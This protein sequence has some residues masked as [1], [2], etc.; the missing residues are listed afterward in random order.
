MCLGM[1]SHLKRSIPDLRPHKSS[2][3][4][5]IGKF[6]VPKQEFLNNFYGTIVKIFNYEEISQ[7]DQKIDIVKTISEKIYKIFC[8]SFIN[9]RNLHKSI[10]LEHVQCMYVWCKFR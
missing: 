5:L 8:N 3:Q 7:L 2:H 6:Y 4:P 9:V 10:L 1:F